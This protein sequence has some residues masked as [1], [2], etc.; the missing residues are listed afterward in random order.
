MTVNK[1]RTIWKYKLNKVATVNYS[2]KYNK[3]KALYK[4]QLLVTSW[5]HLPAS[6]VVALVPSQQ[7]TAA[8]PAFEMLLVPTGR[9]THTGW[10]IMQELY[11]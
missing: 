10:R 1:N 9:R 4:T 3:K 7:P 6:F 11:R 8:T 5:V 2:E